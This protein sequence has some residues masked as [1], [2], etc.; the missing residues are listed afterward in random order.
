[1][2]LVSTILAVLM[3]TAAAAIAQPDRADSVGAGGYRFFDMPIDPERYLLRPDERLQVTFL[4]TALAPL[5]VRVNPEGRIVHPTLGSFDLRGATLAEARVA[6]VKA[7]SSLYQAD[8]I[9]ISVLAPRRVAIQV[10]GAVQ[11]PGLYTVYTSQRVSEVID[12]AGGL[13]PSGSRRLIRLLGGPREIR[14]DLDRALLGDE[15]WNPPLY[16]GYTVIVPAKSAR[17]VNVVGAVDRPRD[18]EIV[19]GES[20]AEILPLVGPFR[21]SADTLAVQIIRGSERLPAAGVPLQAEDIVFVPTLSRLAEGA[22]VTV[23][24]AVAR[25]GRFLLSASGALSEILDAA[26]GFAPDA[27]R[28]ELTVFRQVPLEAALRAGE[29]Y[30]IANLIALDGAVQPFTLQPGDSIFVPMMVG[31][32]KVSGEVRNPGMFPFRVGGTARDYVRAAGGF[33]P[34][35]DREMVEIFHRVSRLTEE[36]PAEVVVHDGDEVIVRLREEFR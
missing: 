32:V 18:I 34:R 16:A 2:R 36:H 10:S 8:S 31:Y 9:D 25:P 3:V 19:D 23:Y 33:L 7:L 5:S 26:G 6:L 11:S 28:S 29:R 1:M 17:V 4:G 15:R 22:P 21:S 12:S 14:V 30:S 35:A 20:V 13:S 24:G 27:A